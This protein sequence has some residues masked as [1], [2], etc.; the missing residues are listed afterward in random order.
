MALFIIL[1]LTVGSIAELGFEK[2]AYV[3]IIL[4]GI[5]FTFCLIARRQ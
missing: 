4:I 2:T 1:A 3:Y 5:V